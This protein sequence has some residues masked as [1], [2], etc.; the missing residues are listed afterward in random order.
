MKEPIIDSKYLSRIRPD[1]SAQPGY[2]VTKG[3][4]HGTFT[5]SSWLC[6]EDEKY[7]NS[8]LGFQIAEIKCDIESNKVKL[9]KLRERMLQTEH[10][11]NV[12]KM[13][14]SNESVVDFLTRQ[15]QVAK[16]E[17]DNQKN[18]VS[19]IR[20]YLKNYVE[21]N[22]RERKK[23]LDKILDEIDIESLENEI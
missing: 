4:R 14:S 10:L 21:V 18:L 16:R 3:T 13:S 12:A 7:K 11:L 2:Q 8:I 17:Y 22:L 15:F 23:T 19:R 9:H 5:C 6:K 1:G 20:E